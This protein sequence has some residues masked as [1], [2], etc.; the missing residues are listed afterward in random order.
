MFLPYR[1]DAYWTVFNKN[2]YDWDKMGLAKL[3]FDQRLLSL[4]EIHRSSAKRQENNGDPA[5][6]GF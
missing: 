4:H 6:T 3:V 5:L 2:S 1:L